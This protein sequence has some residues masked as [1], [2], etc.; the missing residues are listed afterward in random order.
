MKADAT[1]LLEFFE[2]NQTNQFVIPIYQRVYSWEKE[3]CKQLWDDIIKTGGND[4]MNG[5]FIGSIVFVQDGIY[6]TNYNELLIIDGQ[7]RLTTITLLFI[8]LRDHLNDEY[9]LLEK[10]SRQKVQNRYLINSDEKD[11]KKFKLILSEPDR[12]TLLYLIDKDKRKPSE[13]SLK[14]MENFK[15][16]EDMDP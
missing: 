13:L 1:T 3:Q 5:H 11:D 2:Q 9:E 10:F 15:L 8:A 4:Q 12:D 14:I 6:T 16:F 7:Q